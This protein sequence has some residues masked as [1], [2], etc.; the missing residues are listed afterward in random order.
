MILSKKESPASFWEA[1][2]CGAKAP[3]AVLG[4]C[5]GIEELVAC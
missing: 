3:R 4:I 5:L 2:V 1:L